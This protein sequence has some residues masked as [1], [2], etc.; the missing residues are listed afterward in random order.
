EGALHVGLEL[1][2]RLQLR[3]DRRGLEP[4]VLLGDVG[5]VAVD[6]LERPVA[7]TRL[8]LPSYLVL[9]LV[10]SLLNDRARP[11]REID[12]GVEVALAADAADPRGLGERERHRLAAVG[13]GERDAT[14]RVLPGSI[15]RHGQ[16]HPDAPPLAREERTRP[17]DDRIAGL[18]E[19]IA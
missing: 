3:P 13:V 9:H 2:E 18:L 10:V 1:L 11:R 12:V 4:G 7:A 19:R 8:H 17:E 16:G 5:P 6:A 14:E 15:V